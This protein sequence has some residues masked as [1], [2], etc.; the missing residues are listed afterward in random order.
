MY[1]CVSICFSVTALPASASINTCNHQY[2]T[3][4]RFHAVSGQTKHSGYVKGNQSVKCC[5]RRCSR[6]EKRNQDSE[7][8]CLLYSVCEGT[9]TSMNQGVQGKCIT[10]KATPTR[11]TPFSK[12]KGAALGGTQTHDTLLS[13]Q[14]T[15]PTELPGQLSRQGSKS[16]TQH[17]TRQSQTPILC[18][19]AQKPP[20]LICR[21]N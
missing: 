1:V 19:M 4:S 20:H 11:A 21:G 3:A 2:Y 16:T 8:N 10:N 12:E 7:R 17:N 5:C 13:R 18:A 15:L 14:S 9:R 6:C